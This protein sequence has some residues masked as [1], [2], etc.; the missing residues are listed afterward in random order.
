MFYIAALIAMLSFSVLVL[1][2]LRLGQPLWSPA[3]LG[4]FYTYV[5]SFAF[6]SVVLYFGAVT[7]GIL[8]LGRRAMHTLLLRL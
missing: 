7:V 5:G 1:N 8:F 4:E 3:V 2:S 6:A